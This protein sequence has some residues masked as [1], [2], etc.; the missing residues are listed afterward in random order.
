MEEWVGGREGRSRL[1]VGEVQDREGA[2]VV[3]VP[4]CFASAAKDK[5][6]VVEVGYKDFL[7]AVD[8]EKNYT[9]HSMV[10]TL[11]VAAA[12]CAGT[13]YPAVAAAADIASEDDADSAVCQDDANEPNLTDLAV[14]VDKAEIPVPA[15]SEVE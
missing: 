8:A 13:T 5:I 11:T 12:P 7:A 9:L 1:E 14:E 4:A 3:V 6:E 10:L 2:F 15:G